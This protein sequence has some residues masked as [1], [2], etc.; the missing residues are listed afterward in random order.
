MASL[1]GVAA[2]RSQSFHSAIMEG[3]GDYAMG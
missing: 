1:Q 3:T 2:Q